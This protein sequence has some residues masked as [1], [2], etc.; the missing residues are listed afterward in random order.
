[1]AAGL[2]QRLNA[3]AQIEWLGQTGSTNADLMQ[4]ARSNHNQLTRPWLLGAHLQTAG[5]GRAG[6]TWH[7]KTGVNLMF[8]CAFD[9][10]IKARDL[11]TITSFIGTI[12]CKTLRGLLN[13]VIQPKLELKWPNDILWDGAKLAGILIESTRSSTS[14]SADHHL[15]VIGLGI[16]LNSSNQLSQSLQREIADWQQIRAADPRLQHV[17]A[18]DLVAA[19]ANSWYHGLNQVSAHGFIGL[20]EEYA[21]YDALLNQPVNIIDNDKILYSGIA[22]GIDS[23]GHLLVQTGPIKHAVAVGEVSVRAIV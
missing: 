22:T 2:R 10:F 12:T 6:R 15:V 11:A 17:N 23:F 4:R 8:S 21:K 16:N 3:F 20:A 14:K 13:P 9:V 18:V 7:N 5:R 1:M 19:L